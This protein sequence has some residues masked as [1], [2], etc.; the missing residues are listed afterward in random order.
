MSDGYTRDYFLGDCEGHREFLESGG[1]ILSPRLRGTL[2]L[3]RAELRD[4][5]RVLEIGFGRGELL[6]AVAREL[7]VRAFGCE[8]AGDAVAIAAGLN[9][10]APAE[11]RPRLVRGAIAALPFA[12]ASFD[13]VLLIDVVEHIAAAE[14]TAAFRVLRGLLRPGG[15]IVVHTQPNLWHFRFGYPLYRLLRGLK[16]RHWLPKEPR[17]PS[18]FLLHINE[19]SPLSLWRLGWQAGLR[20]RIWLARPCW[21]S[22]EGKPAAG[23]ARLAQC[24]LPIRLLFYKEL[25]AVYRRCG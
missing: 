10:A 1:S 13:V 14:L 11:R 4:G 12:P 18:D 22:Q 7:S 23:L 17:Q 20:A 21:Y 6:H 24:L 3:V 25:Y 8:A 16:N 9:R 15:R 5:D 19:Q 2:A